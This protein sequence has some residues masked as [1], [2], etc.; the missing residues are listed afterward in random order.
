MADRP[1]GPGAPH[2]SSASAGPGAPAGSGA[3]G[4][5]ERVEPAWQVVLNAG[6][7]LIFLFWPA[8]TM[9]RADVGP[10]LKAV[11]FAGLA[12]FVVVYLTAFLRPHPLAALPQWVSSVGYSLAMVAALAVAMP[13]A[14]VTVTY[15]VPYFV[16]LWLFSHPLRVG[17]VGAGVAALAGGAAAMVVSSGDDRF[18]YLMPLGFSVVIIGAIRF[19]LAKEEDALRLREELIRSQQREAVARDVHDVLGHS[20]TVVAVKTEL[21]RR[22]LTAD[23]DRARAELDD[24]LTLARESLAEVRATVGGLRVPELPAQLAAARTA[25]DAAGIAARIPGPDAADAI[26]AAQREVFAWCLR[27]GV[28]NVVRHSGAQRCSVTLQ[29]GQLVVVDDG[30][31][32][33]LPA[34]TTPGSGLA[35]LRDRVEQAGGTLSLVPDRPERTPPGARLEVRL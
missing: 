30:V 10:V 28:T 22:L 34:G 21:A 3:A 18:W 17:L 8:V 12:A 4:V 35:G 23:P 25:L 2:G 14:G 26:P 24:V 11:S 27:E 6:I 20:L 19:S 13:A 5:P 9:V 33:M 16:A 29:P 31:G 7:W 15:L 1:G 32:P